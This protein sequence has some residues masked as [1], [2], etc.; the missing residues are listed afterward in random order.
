MSKDHTI[1]TIKRCPYCGGRTKADMN[2][3]HTHFTDAFGYTLPLAH[4]TLRRTCTNCGYRYLI[5]EVR[6]DDLKEYLEEVKRRL[7]AR[8]L[9][10][11]NE[12]EGDEI[13]PEGINLKH[14]FR[15]L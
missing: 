13:T 2:V 10:K 6:K 7:A 8:I 3:F 14:L 9:R 15:E 1:D 5:I 12:I 11:I 4:Y